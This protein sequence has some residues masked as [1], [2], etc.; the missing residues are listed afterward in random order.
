MENILYAGGMLVLAVIAWL[1]GRFSIKTKVEVTAE[2]T[3]KD[4]ES[5]KTE[6]EKARVT[7]QQ[8]FTGRMNNIENQNRLLLRVSLVQLK[9]MQGENLNGD[10]D[11]ALEAVSEY[12][13]NK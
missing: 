5:Y 9:A 1:S 10:V 6:N 8:N 7:C 13:I 2:K 11:S 12:L 3:S 4:L